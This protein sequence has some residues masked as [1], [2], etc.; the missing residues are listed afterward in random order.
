MSYNRILFLFLT[1]FYVN[2]RLE[3]QWIVPW[4]ELAF[5]KEIVNDIFILFKSTDHVDKFY[6]KTVSL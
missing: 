6:E 3:F 2:K 5:I 4:V 1:R